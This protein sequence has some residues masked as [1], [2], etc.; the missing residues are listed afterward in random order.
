MECKEIVFGEAGLM[1]QVLIET[2]WNVK[3]GGKPEWMRRAGINRNI[4]ECKDWKSINSVCYERGIN[5]NIVE[6]KEDWSTGS[7]RTGWV[8]IE[9]SW[10]VKVDI[11]RW[12]ISPFRINRN[13]VEC[14]VQH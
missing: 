6:C 9:T 10:N 5:R 3:E 1:L 11:L 7:I 12:I 2:S 8:L 14:K 4:V 13:I